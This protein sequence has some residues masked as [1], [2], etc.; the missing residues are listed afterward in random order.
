MSNVDVS[1]IIPA[2]NAIKYI[3]RAIESIQIQSGLSWEL[4]VVEN[5]STDDT[6]NKCLS[7]AHKDNRVK[8]IQSEKGVSNARNKGLDSAVG[9]WICF[10]DADDYLYPDTFKSI[11]D[12][13]RN[14][15]SEA[16]T[17]WTQ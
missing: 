16:Y 2:Y 6:Y 9:Q 15:R 8:V 14:K 5:G 11:A 10:L 12:I 13:K 7:Y 17:F 1:V 3:G 4:I